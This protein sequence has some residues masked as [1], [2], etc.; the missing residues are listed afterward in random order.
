MNIKSSINQLISVDQPFTKKKRRKEES[1]N[2]RYIIP[3]IPGISSKL[4][5]V[6]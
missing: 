1:L 4:N 5:V 3:D 2:N 6:G